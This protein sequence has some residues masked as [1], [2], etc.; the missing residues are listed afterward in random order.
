MALSHGEAQSR[1]HAEAAKT[2]SVAIAAARKAEERFWDNDTQQN[3]DLW[4]DA[5][6]VV[7]AARSAERKAYLAYTNP[8]GVQKTFS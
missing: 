7:T 8:F 1:A 2:T 4:D 5:R 6:D 3:L